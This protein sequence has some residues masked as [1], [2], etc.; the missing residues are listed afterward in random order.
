MRS[1]LLLLLVAVSGSA[2]AWVPP[3][4]VTRGLYVDATPL[5]RTGFW[6]QSKN[7]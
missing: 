5:M 4:N 2:L 1:A 6:E 7:M 3:T